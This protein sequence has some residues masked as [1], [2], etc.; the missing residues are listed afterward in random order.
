[1]HA[2]D[3]LCVGAYF[4]LV[5]LVVTVIAHIKGLAKTAHNG[6]RKEMNVKVSSSGVHER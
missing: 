5:F 6:G 3:Q 2:V 4:E 1:M